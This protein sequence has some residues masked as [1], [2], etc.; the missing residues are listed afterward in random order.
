VFN[1]QYK[2]SIA[3]YLTGNN[4]ADSS[5]LFDPLVDEAGDIIPE[6]VERGIFPNRR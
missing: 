4:E 6:F 2:H 5:L 3:Q 1:V